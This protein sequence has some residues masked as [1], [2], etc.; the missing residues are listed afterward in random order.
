[1]TQ[2]FTAIFDGE[3]F[4]P[5]IPLELA[6]DRRYV[7]TIE[8]EVSP[9]KNENAWDV[10]KAW[11]GKIEAPSDWSI[12]HDR[13]LFLLSEINLIQKPGFSSG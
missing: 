2:Q 9:D 8:D 10:L 7:I 5:E 6:P 1:M 4:R 11:S 12:N 13:Y 3:V